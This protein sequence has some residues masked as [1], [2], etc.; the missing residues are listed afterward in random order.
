M[1][2]TDGRATQPEIYQT[3][4]NCKIGENCAKPAH[5]HQPVVDEMKRWLRAVYPKESADEIEAR[6]QFSRK[7]SAGNT[8]FVINCGPVLRALLRAYGMLEEKNVPL[9]LLTETVGVRKR[10]LEGILDGDGH[11]SKSNNQFELLAKERSVIDGYIHL[12]RGLGFHTGAV[13]TTT[14]K[15]E[16]TDEVYNG[17]RIRMGGIEL[18]SLETVLVYK[19][20]PGTAPLSDQ[21]CDGFSIVPVGDGTFYGFQLDGN[22]RCLLGDFL[23]THNTVMDH[24]IRS[25][26]VRHCKSVYAGCA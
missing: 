19:R 24:K 1:W 11:Y 18:A 20:C 5:S 17:W 26:S 2:I 15:N 4:E 22:G 3:G 14:V 21:R 10:L 8:L 23:V 13:S 9:A 16:E 6:V 25:D 12:A 7:T